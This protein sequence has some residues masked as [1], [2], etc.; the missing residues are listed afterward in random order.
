MGHCCWRTDA[1]RKK[2]VC[3]RV[4]RESMKCRHRREGHRPQKH[5]DVESLCKGSCWWRPLYT[6]CECHNSHRTSYTEWGHPLVSSAAS[7]LWHK[8]S[9]ETYSL[10]I[11]LFQL[12]QRS[13]HYVES[14]TCFPDGCIPWE[15]ALWFIATEFHF[16]LTQQPTGCTKTTFSFYIGVLRS[17]LSRAEQLVCMMLLGVLIKQTDKTGSINSIRE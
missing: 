14:S 6:A 8:K 5:I 1:P 10:P 13:R 2:S 16:L 17:V 11:K 3:C 12:L 15:P 7:H 9:P 4:V